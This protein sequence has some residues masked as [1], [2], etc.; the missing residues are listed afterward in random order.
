[1][2]QCSLNEIESNYFGD[3][4]NSQASEESSF[5]S[6]EVCS[7]RDRVLWGHELSISSCVEVP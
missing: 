2:G 1:M 4:F 6:K 5:L 3:L 7:E